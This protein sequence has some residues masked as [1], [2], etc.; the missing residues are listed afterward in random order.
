MPN[1]L[2]LLKSAACLLVAAVLLTAPLHAQQAQ[3]PI[4]GD[5]G[6][7]IANHA[8]SREQALVAERLPGAVVVANPKGDVTLVEFYDLNCPYCRRASADLD[9][10]IKADRRLRLVLVPYP[11]LGIASVLAGRVELAVARTLPPETFY[12]FHRE[13]YAGRGVIDG[14]RAIATVRTLGLDED[15][16]LM[17]ADSDELTE[18]MKTHARTGGALGL[19]ATPGYV[20]AGVAIVGHPGRKALEQVVASVRRCGKV[21]C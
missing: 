9:A 20:I 3:F 13:I 14:A 17:V 15:K 5:D 10:M 6:R 2:T 1:F 11:V 16:L 8:L 7:P 12:R 21:V 4:T 18:I 19:R